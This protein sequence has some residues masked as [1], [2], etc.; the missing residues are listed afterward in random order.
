MIPEGHGAHVSFRHAEIEITSMIDVLDLNAT[1][2]NES[3]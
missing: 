3:R 1:K 2:E